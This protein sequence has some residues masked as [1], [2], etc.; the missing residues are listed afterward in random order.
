MSDSSLTEEDV[1]KA[2][3]GDIE[4]HRVLGSGAQGTTFQATTNNG[5]VALKVCPPNEDFRAVERAARE[6][7]KLRQVD[8][9]HVVK[10]LDHGELQI[11]DAWCAYLELEFV[12][13]E[14]VSTL[15]DVF[16][17]DE[18]DHEIRQLLRDVGSA[19]DALWSQYILHRDVKPE[20]IIRSSDGRYVLLD[21]GLAKSD[22]D[23]QLTAA[24][25]NPG[26][27]GF[28]APE[29][30]DT[31]RQ[32]HL[33][34]YF[35]LGVTAYLVASG[36]FPFDRFVNPKEQDPPSNLSSIGVSE[37]VSLCVERLMKLRSLDRPM[38]VKEFF[39]EGV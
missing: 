7:D 39:E 2:Y 14:P 21:L 17:G 8:S 26:T 9:P 25:G 37:D 24:G 38:S 30:F 6:A 20:N 3:P 23:Y 29:R 34:D 35:S 27:M 15:V 19:I 22:G 11:G 33:S 32:S 10:L 1:T 31:E 18:R 36:R 12:D 13:G 28:R 16:E 4:I 5:E